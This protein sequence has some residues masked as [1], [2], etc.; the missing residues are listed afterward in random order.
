MLIILAAVA[1]NLSLG[2]NGLFNRAKIAKEQYIN[3][4]EYEKTEVAKSVNDI[5]SN[6]AGN[7]G[8][9]TL[10]EEEYEIFKN[11]TTFSTSEK[12]VGKWTNNQPL[13]RKTYN[14]ENNQ[15]NSS[16]NR[17]IDT[18]LTSD[19]IVIVDFNGKYKWGANNFY[20]DIQDRYR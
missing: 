9:V 10:T 17:Y 1:I 2:N 7:R 8:T 19:N 11:K 18:T 4:Q 20:V 16:G 6:I 12:I 13:Y 5:D 15:S 14:I 3:G